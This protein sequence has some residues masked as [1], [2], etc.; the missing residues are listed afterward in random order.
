MEKHTVEY[1]GQK[2][3][4]ILQRKQVK[5]IN[6]N[7][8]P[9]MV[10]A[11]SA[12][13]KV[14]LDFIKSF[15]KNKAPWLLRNLNYF[16]DAQP[17]NHREKEYVSGE[18]YK[19]LGKQVRLKVEESKQES[20]KYCRG[21]LYLYV[22]NRDNYFRKKSLL[23]K[24]FRTKANA[25]FLESIDR[26][27]AQLRKYGYPK[28]KLKVRLMKARWGSCVKDKGLILLNFELIKAPKYCID[29]VVLHE[30]LHFKFRNHDKNFYDFMTAL[31][32]DW[33]VRK[34]I[35]DDEVV[36]EL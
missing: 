21:F 25:C 33:T 6:L 27:Y 1:N 34:R 9:N 14:P 28:P 32:P 19:Y 10:I 23:N 3:E 4:F 36:R 8:K 31:M 13:E 29:Y 18:S 2:L 30:I 5:Y 20:V 35:L 7:L 26:V 15:V 17:Q 12:N 11:V 16:R 22:K 24:W